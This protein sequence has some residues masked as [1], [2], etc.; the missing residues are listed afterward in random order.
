MTTLAPEKKKGPGRPKETRP[1]ECHPEREFYAHL[2]GKRLCYS[3][4]VNQ[5]HP[6]HEKVEQGYNRTIADKKYRKKQRVLCQILDIPSPYISL[7]E[8]FKSASHLECLSKAL[9]EGNPDLLDIWN[10]LSES[11]QNAI[12]SP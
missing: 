9:K 2:N 5:K 10:D 6:F 4:Y 1:P 7:K 3:C 11:Q 8:L 12:K